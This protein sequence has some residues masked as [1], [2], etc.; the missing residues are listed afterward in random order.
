MAVNTETSTFI[1][2]ITSLF[3]TLENHLNGKTGTAWHALQRKSIDSLIH[4]DFP[5]RSFE[6][7]KYTPVARLIAQ[8]YQL[9]AA[10]DHISIPAIPGFESHVITVANGRMISP[11]PD[12]LIKAGVTLLPM[13]TAWQDETWQTAFSGWY[14]TSHFHPNQ[15]FALLNTSFNTDGFYLRIPAGIKIDK[16]IEFRFVHHDTQLSFSHPL[17]F[18]HAG[19]NSDVEIIER[20]EHVTGDVTGGLINCSVYCHLE[21]NARLRHIRWQHL[22][23]AQHLV[24]RLITTQQRDSHFTSLAFDKGGLLVRN[25]VEVELEE[26]NTYTSLQAGFIARN[27]QS[28]D[29][30]TRINHK[31]PHC[32][33]HELFRC[34]IDDQASAAFNGKVYVHPDAQKTNAFQQNDALVLSPHAVMN[35]K[36]QLEIYADDVKCSHGATIGQLDEKSI[37]YLKSRGISIEAATAMLKAA[38]LETVI[39]QIWIPSVAEYISSKLLDTL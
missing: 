13:H 9:A 30:Q 24:Y 20:F 3:S 39:S 6:D 26:S 7:W 38:F 16:P 1:N 15:A 27:K 32:E 5:D 11:L 4:H 37:F 31:V 22:A 23:P 2:H 35:S 21:P 14:N 17:V 29:H 34:V 28:M 10:M 36:P 8:P 19:K 18:I 33:S 25:N 12:G